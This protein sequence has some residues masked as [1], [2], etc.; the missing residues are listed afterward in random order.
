LFEKIKD[1][2]T[3]VPKMEDAK[4]T[5]DWIDRYKNIQTLQTDVGKEVLD[6]YI[7]LMSQMGDAQLSK[8]IYEGKLGR[9]Y[10]ELESGTKFL[11]PYRKVAQ[12]ICQQDQAQ[13]IDASGCIPA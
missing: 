13:N 12:K 1:F 9:I 5:D 11:E 8:D 7:R 3:F 6:K 10:I 2:Y 4:T